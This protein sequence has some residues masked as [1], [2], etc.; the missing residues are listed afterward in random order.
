MCNLNITLRDLCTFAKYLTVSQDS[1]RLGGV[2]VS[3]R[4]TGPKGRVFEPGQGDGFLR[5]IKFRSTP[6][7]RLGSK[8]GG[9]I[10]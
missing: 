6:S 1:R 10:P 8:D 9:P 5:P 7:S 4:A 3:M 2:L